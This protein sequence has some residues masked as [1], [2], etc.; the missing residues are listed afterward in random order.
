MLSPTSGAENVNSTPPSPSISP[1]PSGSQRRFKLRK[2]FSFSGWRVGMSFC[3]AA[4]AAVFVTNLGATIGLMTAHGTEGNGVGTITEGQCSRMKN[5]SLWLHLAINILGT[6]L[7]AA[8][9][10]CMQILSAPTRA[11]VD[12]AHRKGKWLDIGV[13]SIRNLFEINKRRACLWLFLGLSSI[14]IHL[15]SVTLVISG[16]LSY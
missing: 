8:S 9:N 10:Y 3:I 1:P 11:E 13:P 4:T 5:I 12:K 7:L 6:V 14:P 16:L 2:W 15:L